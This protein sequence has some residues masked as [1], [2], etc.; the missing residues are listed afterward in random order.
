MS[1]ADEVSAVGNPSDLLLAHLSPRRL[2]LSAGLFFAGRG[3]FDAADYL[4]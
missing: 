2:H 1:H 4:A 3:A